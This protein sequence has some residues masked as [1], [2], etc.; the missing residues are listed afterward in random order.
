MA[1]N[2]GSTPTALKGRSGGRPPLKAPTA[3]VAKTATPDAPKPRLS[4]VGWF[5]NLPKFASEVRAEARKT[6]WT[7]WRETWITSVMVFIMVVV[8]AVFF[9][10]VDQALG[11]GMKFLLKLAG[12]N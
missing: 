8:T 3:P 6:T 2:P 1:R 7:T 9:L 12:G 4:L 5:L 10:V 11:Q